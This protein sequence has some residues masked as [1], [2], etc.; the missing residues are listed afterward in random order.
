MC[1]NC[2]GDFFQLLATGLPL[3]STTTN[4]SGKHHVLA[5]VLWRAHQD[6]V[7]LTTNVRQE[8]DVPFGQLLTRCRFGDMTEEDI[9]TL[10][11]RSI[12]HPQS[13]VNCNTL[14]ERLKSS[15]DYVPVGTASTHYYY[16]FFFILVFK[17]QL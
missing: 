5:Q 1:L 15:D 7:I 10:Q 11:H 6:I 12:D 3:Y 16:L 8:S 17:C 9:D 2:R 13:I 4:Q 14:I